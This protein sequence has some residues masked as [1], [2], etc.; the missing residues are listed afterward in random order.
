MYAIITCVT[1]FTSISVFLFLGVCRPLKSWWDV[2]VD[3]VCLPKHQVESI[4]LA[5]GG[6]SLIEIT[7][8]VLRTDL[9]DD[10]VIGHLRSCLGSPS[11]NILKKPPDLSPDESRLVCAHG[12]GRDVGYFDSLAGNEY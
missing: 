7:K 1:V 5:Q 3:G 11:G 10:S 12:T 2:G 6:R 9:N 4:V 8:K